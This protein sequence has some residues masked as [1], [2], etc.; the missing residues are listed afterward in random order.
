LPC[1]GQR[2]LKE[3]S[4]FSLRFPGQL[5]LKDQYF[6]PRGRQMSVACA[7]FVVM[8]FE[9]LERLITSLLKGF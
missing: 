4:G 1:T 9:T 2:T 8:G 6:L 5:S 7:F 3:K